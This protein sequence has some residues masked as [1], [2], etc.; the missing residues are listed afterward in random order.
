MIFSKNKDKPLIGVSFSP[1]ASYMMWYSTYLALKFAGANA[2]LLTPDNYEDFE[3]CAGYII[4]GGNDINPEIYGQKNS[5]S[6]NIDDKRDFFEVHLLEYALKERKPLLGI[7][8][9]MQMINVMLGGTLYQDAK[10]VFSDFLPTTSTFKKIFD[11]RKVHFTKNNLIT[12]QEYLWVNSI[13]HQALDK[14]GQEL[15]VIAEDEFGMIQAY[16]HLD[17]EHFII[18]VQWH[19]E[20]MIYDRIRFQIFKKLV[21]QCKTLSDI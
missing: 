10:S 8:R 20:F 18:G 19:P 5:Y 4:S 21:Q 15:H 6:L 12:D 11:R 9:G 13:H 7:C 3:R 17:K 2:V 14:I 16:E 1:K